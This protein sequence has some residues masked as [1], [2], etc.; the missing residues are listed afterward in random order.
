MRSYAIRHH[1]TIISVLVVV[2]LFGLY[3]AH[4]CDIFKNSNVEAVREITTEL[5]ETLLLAE[6]SL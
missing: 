2:L 6:S 3:L 1:R 4:E 5:D